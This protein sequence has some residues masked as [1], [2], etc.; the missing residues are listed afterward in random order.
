[1]RDPIPCHVE[2]LD[3]R[4]ARTGRDAIPNMQEIVAYRNSRQILL[5]DDLSSPA[6][7]RQIQRAFK[8]TPILLRIAL[9]AFAAS[10]A[11]VK[12]AMPPP[13]IATT[14]FVML[15][16]P[17]SFVDSMTGEGIGM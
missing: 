4:H 13:M 11:A 2:P 1:M 8:L 10:A 12:P 9:P 6:R 7:L 3:F 15:I 5:R 14:Y 16:H 17:F